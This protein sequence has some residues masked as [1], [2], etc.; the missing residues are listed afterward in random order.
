M[1]RKSSDLWRMLAS[2]YIVLRSVDGRA[3]CNPDPALGLESKS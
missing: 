1:E 2:S 3:K